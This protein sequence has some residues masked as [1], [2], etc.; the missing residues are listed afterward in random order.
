VTSGSPTGYTPANQDLAQQRCILPL[1]VLIVAELSTCPRTIRALLELQDLGCIQ[2]L[3]RVESGAEA[4]QATTVLLPDL[5]ILDH[6]QDT[7]SQP[8]SSVLASNF[9]A[10]KLLC[11][12]EED[13]A[14][15]TDASLT[16]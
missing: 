8:L 13:S 9:P 10:V 4:L 2:I 3:G 6:C 5:I 11:F 7:G 15:L 12:A 1:Q 16:C 14:R